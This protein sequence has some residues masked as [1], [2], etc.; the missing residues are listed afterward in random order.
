[1][2]PPATSDSTVNPGTHF[3]DNA[4]TRAKLDVNR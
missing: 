2:K 3:F 1:M 4:M